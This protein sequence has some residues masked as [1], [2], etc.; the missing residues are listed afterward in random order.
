MALVDAQVHRSFAFENR[1]DRGAQK[2]FFVAHASI[3]GHF[4]GAFVLCPGQG[5]GDE[6]G[7]QALD[8]QGDAVDRQARE[9]ELVGK[10]RHQVLDRPVG[11]PRIGQQPFNDRLQVVWP[12]RSLFRSSSRGTVQ[13]YRG[14]VAHALRLLPA[15]WGSVRF[16]A[17]NWPV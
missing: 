4:Q 13:L 14:I 12:R 15:L 6:E 16:A 11:Q 5:A 7:M 8:M 17:R 2:G 10:L 9:L 3:A 1:L